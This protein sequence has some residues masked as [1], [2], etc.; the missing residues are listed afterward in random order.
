[1][2]TAWRL[3]RPGGAFLVDVRSPDLATL[4]ESQRVKPRAFVDLD[5]DATRQSLGDE[6]RLLRCAATTYE[7]HLQLANVR[8]LYDRFDALGRTSPFHITL[9]RKPLQP[10]SIKQRFTESEQ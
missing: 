8:L 3:L 1:V 6:A 9:T 7:L 4:S 5:I 2:A 10:P